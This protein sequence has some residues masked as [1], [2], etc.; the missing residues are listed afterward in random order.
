MP[1]TAA[2]SGPGRHR[3]LVDLI[4]PEA[5]MADEEDE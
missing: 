1:P 2:T 4:F 5:E 3:P